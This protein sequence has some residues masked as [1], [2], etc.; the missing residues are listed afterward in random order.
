MEDWKRE[1]S[2]NVTMHKP[3]S[4]IV[5]RESDHKPPTSWKH[6]DVSPGRVV[7]VQSADGGITE[8]AGPSTQDIEIMPVEMNRVGNI[9]R[10]SHGF[11]DHPVSPL[12]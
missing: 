4:W 3:S 9:D 2:Y 11:L 8:P 12:W 5:C 10:A 1:G 7:E 6:S